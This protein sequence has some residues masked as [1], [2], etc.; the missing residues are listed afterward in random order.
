MDAWNVLAYSYAPSYTQA[1]LWRKT[2]W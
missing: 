1:E 2:T